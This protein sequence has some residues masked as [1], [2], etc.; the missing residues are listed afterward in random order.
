MTNAE[1][2]AKYVEAMYVSLMRAS[3]PYADGFSEPTLDALERIANN[4]HCGNGYWSWDGML[5]DLT[6]LTGSEDIASTILNN[7]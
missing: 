6:D 4:R 3:Q 1:R 2:D 5:D 7:C